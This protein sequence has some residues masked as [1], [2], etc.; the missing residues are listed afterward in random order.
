MVVSVAVHH[1]DYLAYF[2]ELAGKN[3][4]VSFAKPQDVKTCHA[5]GQSVMLDNGAFSVWKRD[6]AMKFP[7]IATSISLR[8]TA[9]ARST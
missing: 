2:N 3:F 5:I 9:R 6:N 1:P 4:C 8:L 7:I